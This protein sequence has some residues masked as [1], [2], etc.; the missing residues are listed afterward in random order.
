[1]CNTQNIIPIFV[2][3]DIDEIMRKQKFF[4]THFTGGPAL[5]SREYG[6][7]AMRYRH[8]PHEITPTRAKSWLRCMKDAFD[9]TGLSELPAG[10]AFYKRLTEV[11]AIMVNTDDDA[12]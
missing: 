10:D 2:I 1:M 4:L 6:R 7:P 8:L 9:G 11:P 3:V 5:Y 12:K